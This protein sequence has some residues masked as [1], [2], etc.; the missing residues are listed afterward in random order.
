MR[1]TVPDSAARELGALLEQLAVMVDGHDRLLVA[2]KRQ[3]EAIRRAD[4]DDLSLTCREE[5]RLVAHLTAAHAKRQR[6]MERVTAHLAPGSRRTLGLEEIVRLAP[7]RLHDAFGE[8]A[9]R[10]ASARDEIRRESAIVREASEA[11]VRHL[12]GIIQTVHASV[13]GTNVYE[14]RG[15]LVTPGE[16]DCCIDL[17]T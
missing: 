10:L 16:G 3:R 17:R 15:R 13:V 2:V 8:L 12:G 14:R 5:E 6:L 9:R 1:P 11:L 4:L 7:E